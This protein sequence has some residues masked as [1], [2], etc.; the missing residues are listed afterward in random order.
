M[1]DVTSKE[2]K[3]IQENLLLQKM[4]NKLMNRNI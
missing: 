1:E 3:K 4:V 2:K